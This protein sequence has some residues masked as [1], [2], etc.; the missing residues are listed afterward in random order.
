VARIA[1]VAWL[2]QVEDPFRLAGAVLVLSLQ[3]PLQRSLWS[4]GLAPALTRRRD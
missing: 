1:L 2:A 4:W 3:V